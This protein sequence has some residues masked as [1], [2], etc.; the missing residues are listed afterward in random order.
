MTSNELLYAL[1]EFTEA[2]VKDLMLPVRFQKSDDEQPED[3]TP[4]VYLMRLPDS[5]SATKKAPYILHQRVT[6][7]DAQESGQKTIAETVIRTVFCVYDEDGQQGGLRLNE[8]M[9]RVRIPLLRQRVIG[10]QF[11]LQMDGNNAPQSLVYTEDTAPYYIGEMITTWRLPPIERE[12]KL[13]GEYENFF[14]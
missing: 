6:S 5:T 1:K 9:D 7:R 3:R 13:Y 10:D 11:D 12:V 8:V 2:A 14:G 4:T